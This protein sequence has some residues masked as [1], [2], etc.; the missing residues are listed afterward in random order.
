MIWMYTASIAIMYGA[1]S[2]ALVA[3]DIT[4]LIMCAKLRMAPLFG[5]MVESL[6]RKNHLPALLLALGSLT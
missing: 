1:D 3:N 5:G 2:L 6:D 4:C